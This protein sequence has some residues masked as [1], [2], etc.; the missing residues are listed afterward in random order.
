MRR[1]TAT[2]AVLTAVALTIAGCGS[3]DT[4]DTAPTSS[5]TPAAE[6]ANAPETNG[7]VPGTVVPIDGSPEGIVIGASGVAAVALRDPDTLAL[8]DATT[9]RTTGVVPTDGAARHLSLAGPDGPVLAPLEQSDTLAVVSLPG[10]EVESIATGVGRQPHDAVQTSDGTIAV[11]NEMGGGAIFVRDGVVVASL[12][13]G[14]VQ[15][16]GAA[17]V[18]ARAV[19]ADVQGNGIFVYDGPRT[20]E[21]GSAPIGTKLTHVVALG[22]DSDVV[23][24]ADTDGG[25]VELVRISGEPVQIDQIATVDAPGTP[26]GLAADPERRRLYVTETATN[27]MLVVDVADPAAPRVVGSVPTVRQP[28]SLAVDPRTGGV[29]VTG[30][31]DRQLQVLSLQDVLG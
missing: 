26:Y 27:S 8:V 30:T 23:A 6:P 22:P 14:P 19:F 9:G 28:N 31:A 16:G 12:P 20:T 7:S 24:L 5:Q 17:A 11:T 18:G 3:G 10:G 1:L 4:P 15:P 25:K 29:I 21:V 13:P 2:A